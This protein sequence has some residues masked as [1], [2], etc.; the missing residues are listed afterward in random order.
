MV[1]IIYYDPHKIRINVKGIDK[2][3][4]IQR[5]LKTDSTLN[6][7]ISGHSDKNSTA[8][9]AQKQSA[10]RAI[11]V[12]N[13]L[14]NNDVPASRMRIYYWG[15]TKVIVPRSNTLEQWKNRRVEIAVYQK[16][17]K[18][19]PILAANNTGNKTAL[20]HKKKK[21]VNENNDQGIVNN[22]STDINSPAVIAHGKKKRVSI[23]TN[24]SVDTTTVANSS[25]TDTVNSGKLRIRVKGK[26]SFAAPNDQGINS[27]NQSN[28]TAAAI[29]N[30]DSL[31]IH[32]KN[33][34][35]L[36]APNNPGI[37]GTT[38]S[39]DTTGNK[40]PYVYKNIV[41]KNY[42]QLSGDTT[43]AGTDT[44]NIANK[45]AVTNIAPA[46]TIDTANSKIN[47]A[48]NT[49]QTPTDNSDRN[50]TDNTVTGASKGKNNTSTDNTDNLSTIKR[51]PITSN[52]TINTN[53][54]DD[55]A[56]GAKLTIKV[57]DKNTFAVKNNP[58]VNNNANGVNDANTSSTTSKSN[59]STTVKSTHITANATENNSTAGNDIINNKNTPAVK[60]DQS[61]K[62]AANDE[63][64]AI[65]SATKDVDMGQTISHKPSAQI[66]DTDKVLDCYTIYFDPNDATLNSASFDILDHIR[67]IL[68]LDSSLYIGISGYSERIGSET[69]AQ[70]ISKERAFLARDYMNSYGVTLDRM[71]V[72]YWGS[73]IP[74]ADD[75]DPYQQWENRRVEICIYVYPK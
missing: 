27:N 5:L 40:K 26:D 31:T 64:A 37:N 17:P 54:A 35:G 6:L 15:A 39:A 29:A 16:P 45:S 65:D 33:R 43:A 52:N 30:S 60:N 10:N 47:P 32:V 1:Y 72:S 7:K 59:T 36:T 41:V 42:D 75:N 8:K 34:N 73:K 69:S 2:L 74:V 28:N 63:Q 24:N 50:I 14:K 9:I 3:S 12:R 11:I 18:A 53:N 58:R 19:I 71:R 70:K 38:T 62:N 56:N 46:N 25:N 44:G 66:D 22:N 48:K 55:V 51:S 20:K 67:E 13:Y 23:P 61:V 57:K 4:R 49:V 68:R 21:P